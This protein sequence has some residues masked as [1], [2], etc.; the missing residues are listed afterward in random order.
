MI[1]NYSQAAP[2]LLKAETIWDAPVVFYTV[3]DTEDVL[4]S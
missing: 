1:L 2:N 4:T 3:S